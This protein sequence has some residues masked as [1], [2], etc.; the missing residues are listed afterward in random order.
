MPNLAKPLA[1]LFASRKHAVVKPHLGK[2]ETNC[3]QSFKT[4]ELALSEDWGEF[5]TG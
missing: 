5:I 2:W 1:H 3:M 4:E